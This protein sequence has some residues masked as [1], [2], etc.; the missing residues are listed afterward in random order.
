MEFSGADIVK[1]AKL[2]SPP[3]EDTDS[4]DDFRDQMNPSHIG[5]QS[6]VARD[7]TTVKPQD[8]DAIWKDDEVHEGAE[9]QVEDPRPAPKYEILYK[10]KVTAEDIY[11]QVIMQSLSKILQNLYL[12]RVLRL[13]LIY[14]NVHIR[15]YIRSSLVAPTSGKTPPPMDCESS[16]SGQVM[17]GVVDELRKREFSD[18]ATKS[19][20]WFT[21][22]ENGYLANSGINL[23]NHRLVDIY[24]DRWCKPSSTYSCMIR[25]KLKN[26][27]ISEKIL[28]L[29]GLLW[30]ENGLDVGQ[31]TFLG[32]GHSGAFSASRHCECP[33]GVG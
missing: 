6:D 33:V 30:Q 28:L 21:H 19:Y 31:Y 26:V 15:L 11:L 24:S 25:Y 3:E 13:K 1:L 8:P 5:P 17:A 14:Y 18:R 27:K 16:Q 4:E 22:V 29:L 20:C 2:I 10:Q 9:Y 12:D 7:Q 32:N 23:E